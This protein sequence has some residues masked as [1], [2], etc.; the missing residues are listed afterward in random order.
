MTKC[1]LPL[2]ALSHCSKNLSFHIVI[3]KSALYPFKKNQILDSSKLKEFADDNFKLDENSRK[4]P[5][6]V[7]NTIEKGEI[8]CNEQF[9]LFPQ[10]CLKDFYCRH[11][12]TRASFGY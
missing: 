8:A 12:K 5:H 10:F 3:L 1:R 6:W 2:S 4:F 9:L 7:E 11:K